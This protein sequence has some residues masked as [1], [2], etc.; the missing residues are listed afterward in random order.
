MTK[1]I[2]FII[3]PYL[4]KLVQL[5]RDINYGVQKLGIV[6]IEKNVGNINQLFKN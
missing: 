5:E 3:E 4:V 1:I 6:N 2:K